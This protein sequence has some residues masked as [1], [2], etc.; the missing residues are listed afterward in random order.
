MNKYAGSYYIEEGYSVIVEAKSQKEATEKLEKLMEDGDY[1]GE[2]VHRDY[3]I[4][5]ELKKVVI[6]Q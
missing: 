1:I 2:L 6:T 5:N 3:G 4:D